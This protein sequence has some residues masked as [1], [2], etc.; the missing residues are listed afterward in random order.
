VNPNNTRRNLLET[1]F[2]L[3]CVLA[4]SIPSAYAAPIYWDGV[5]A[6]WESAANWSTVASATTPDPAA[7]PAATD[8]AIFNIDTV[9]GTTT[10]TL[11]AAQSVNS[12]VFNNTG[13]TLIDA[14]GAARILT[15]GAGGLTVDP[16]AGAVTIGGTTA[17]TVTLSA[18][19]TWHNPTANTLTLL[20][21]VASA[22]TMGSGA[23]LTK[24]GTGNVWFNNTTNSH[25]IN[26][27][28]DV[29][30]GKVQFSGDLFV[31]GLTGSGVVECGGTAIKW[32]F[33]NSPLNQ[34]FAGTFQNG[35]G[36]RS[37]FVKRGTGTLT[38][39]GSTG[40]GIDNFAIENGKIVIPTGGSVHVGGT[41]YGS[42]N[43]GNTGNAANNGILEISGGTLT[44]ARTNNPGFA[45][46][47]GN[48]GRGF[49]KM[50]S[51]TLAVTEQ[52]KVGNG[53]A[54]ATPAHAGFT[55]DGGTVTSG[56][57]LVV[58]ANFDR[59]LLTQNGGSI[60]VNANRMT[61]GAGGN[62]S[63][64]VVNLTGGTFNVAAGTN[65]GI[66][67]GENG[68][69][70]LNVTGSAAL[71]LATNGGANSGTM[72]FGGNASGLAGNLNLLGG[73]LSTFG[74]TK[75]ASSAGAVYQF[76]FNGGTLKALA[77]NANFFA[78]LAN[79]E[80]FV[81][82]GGGTIDNN[83][84]NITF[85][86][87]LLAP[88][89][90]G[91]SAT[92]LTVS[93]GG[94]LYP[95]L[96]TI[97]GGGGTGATALASIDAG[98]NL[99]G[100][101]ITNPGINYTSA[102]TFALV[103]GG[104]GNT[105]A[106]SGA[107]TLVANTSG[108]LAFTGTGVT[109][110]AGTNTFT[111]PI[112]VNGGKLA[113]GGTYGA[114]VNVA[115]TA[116]IVV[117]DPAAAVGTLT[118][119]SLSLPNGATATFETGGTTLS[120]K[121]VVSNAGGL[122]LGTVGINL[123]DTGT[124]NP[125]TAG[126]YTLFQY[127]TSFTGGIGG[128]S[129]LNPR[130][131]YSYTFADTGSAITVQVVSVDTDGDG[132]TDAYETANGLNP[133]DATGVNGADGNLDGDFST[134][135]EE[136]L[137]STAANNAAS[138]P[139]NTDNDGLLDSW[140]VT[141]F[142]S[143]AAQTG[144]DDFD[145]DF[146]S[147][148]L[149][150]TN[151][152]APA[153]AASF[154]DTDADGLGDGW[155]ILYFT[156]VT[157]KDGT[158]DSDGDL[159]TDAK[160]YAYRS[161]PVDSS[162]SPVVAQGTHRWSFTGNLNDSIGTSHATIQN[163][164]A[165]NTNVVTQ[166]A[167]SV[168]L[169]G[170]VKADSQWVKLGSQL[171]P[172]RNTPCTIETWATV[173]SIQNYSR[174]WDFHNSTTENLYMSWSV[175]TG[176]STDRVQ[177]VDPN[178]LLSDNTN[179]YA[180]A[181]KYH[182][183]M[184]IEPSP[185]PGSSV[186]KWYSAPEYDGVTN[187]EL[188]VARGSATVANSLAFMND[189]INALGFSPWNDN[190]ANATYDEFRL[191]DGALP[192]WAL[193]GL[194]EQGPD[195][196]AQA[197][198]DGDKMPDAFEKFYF[199]NATTQLPG[200][201]FDNDFSSNVEEMIAGSNPA[202]SSS[203]PNDSDA[204][205][206]PD[207][208]EIGYFGDLDEDGNTDPDGDFA[209]NSE[210]L[211]AGTDPSLY[212]SFPDTD[213]DGM[214]DAWENSY[215]LGLQD[216]GT[217]DDDGDLFDSLAEFT[218]KSDPLNPLSPG[219][220]D[221][222]ADNDSLPDLWETTLFSATNLAT[223]SG[224]ADSDSDGSNNLAEYQATSDP[225]NATSTPTDINGDGQADQHV[226]HGMTA[227]GSGL[228]DKDGT[229]TPFTTRLGGTGTAIA[230]IDPNL[231]LDTTAGSLALTTSTSDI[232]GQVNMAE[233]EAIGIP[234]SSLGFTGTQD[235]RIRA[236]YIDLPVLGGFD[237]IGAYVGTS[238]TAMTRAAKIGGNN[239]ALGVNTNGTNDANAFF[240]ANNSAGLAARD[241]TVVIERIGGVWSMS[242]N[243]SICTP[244]AQP[245]FLDGLATLEGGVFVLD[246][247]SGGTHK[248]AILESFTAVSFGAVT[249]DSDAD[250]LDDDWEIANFGNI[251]AQTGTGDADG[252]GTN[253]RTEYLLGLNPNNGGERFIATESNV[254][255]GTGVTLT[256]PAQDGLTFTVSRSVNLGTWTQLGGTITATGATATYT[257]TTAPVGKAFYK[258]ELTTP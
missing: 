186:V 185:T 7:A 148:L 200:G 203:S 36:A 240:G 197:D 201:D 6:T 176:A 154:S 161:N 14:A 107:A 76:S 21:P 220:P 55:L 128:L 67:L 42:V 213:S 221:G 112:A 31:G 142:G 131:G 27:T 159:F 122:S 32:F 193:Q 189:T 228:Q 132:M 214:S 69:G 89:G 62:G 19:Q 258:V 119:P 104:A 16:S 242:C 102:P 17:V 121:I 23:G 256:W 238:S 44:A 234:L 150:F 237:Q 249:A 73:T 231:D 63:I 138:D 99:T 199:G 33:L 208:W 210:E 57:W 146:D 77:A 195:N 45:I 101:Q 223:Q 187:L 61:I 224:T 86:E 47:G 145:G 2:G 232:N 49:V 75:G 111:G 236:H 239:A 133:N 158:V 257:D 248:T 147:N 105:G 171:L 151:G 144:A 243:G 253:N 181:T 48:N 250:G 13:T 94:Y 1:A 127:T 212:T 39:T 53:S 209:F 134:N 11:N 90:N 198:T 149:E 46:G 190:T 126:T 143:A 68:T 177:W 35:A 227:A 196:A 81:Y 191:W 65:T 60:S 165:S 9:D 108:G 116:G 218:G 115:G 152:T 10:A 5:S 180:L 216:N 78:A 194:H 114:A 96:V 229:A 95:P 83:G 174:V 172:A 88:A 164:T 98:G 70:T 183:V 8:D 255:P 71:T 34:T 170:G 24:T 178:G 80:A 160:E 110:L 18:N 157:A 54:T 141:H 20:N 184:T 4:S 28:L 12:L 173:H 56:S 163:G 26:G 169:A 123:Y 175:G 22:G 125:A 59:A 205:G 130:V 50:T 93:G 40:T 167:T 97:T 136:F 43:V 211:A 74:V 188:G 168:T 103:G 58:G 207:A 51:G 166:D 82:S 87:P 129:V 117:A 25:T 217:G 66:F 124:T 29:Q 245:T 106:L 162:F 120:D 156:N 140:E 235:F 135:Y 179:S 251:A 202:D 84:N 241:M 3:G 225:T 72:Q 215:F 139:K 15:V 222:D 113:L 91:V 206:L 153:S 92:G 118:V 30:A 226:F 246:G 37:G 155:E 41:N 254:V 182:I 137:A 192:P 247:A 85:A 64:G 219:V 233:Q 100:I 38:L 230:A 204:D 109:T 52:L 244:T 252:D 79:T